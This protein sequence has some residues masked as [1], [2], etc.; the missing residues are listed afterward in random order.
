M[1]NCGYVLHEYTAVL[2]IHDVYEDICFCSQALTVFI[3]ERG[4]DP[5]KYELFTHYPRKNLSA[6]ASTSTLRDCELAQQTVFIHER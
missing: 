2:C 6:L 5:D 1:L 4:F 3:A